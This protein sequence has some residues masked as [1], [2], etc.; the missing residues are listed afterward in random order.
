VV[1]LLAEEEPSW[2]WSYSRWIYYYLCNQCLSPLT[3]VW[4]PLKQA[5]LDTTLCDTVCQWLA[6]GRWFA[7][8]TP[9][10]SINYLQVGFVFVVLNATY[11]NISV[12]SWRSVLLLEETG[13]PGAN[14]RPA[15]SHWQTVSHNV[16]SS[17]ACLSGVQTHVS[18]D[19]HW[20]LWNWISRFEGEIGIYDQIV[21]LLKLRTSYEG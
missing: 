13:V 21:F 11:N 14:H 15:A 9:V 19:R 7:P 20:L 4:T 2:S 1:L 3:W 6:A 5:E 12:I 16:V 18:G 17:S 8:G 10:S